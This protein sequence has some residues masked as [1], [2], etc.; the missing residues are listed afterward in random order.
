M[1]PP[2]LAFLRE[3]MR[4]SA[5]RDGEEDGLSFGV[6]GFASV[7]EE[8]AGGGGNWL[9]GQRVLDVGCGGGLLSEVRILLSRPRKVFFV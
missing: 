8:G 9:E 5:L 4:E 2:R 3:K 1:N 7:G 6:G